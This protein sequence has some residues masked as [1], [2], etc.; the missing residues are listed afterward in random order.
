LIR[1]SKN[2]INYHYLDLTDK[3][4]VASDFYYIIPND[5]IVV[6]PINAKFRNLSLVNWPIFLTAI[7]TLATVYLLFYNTQ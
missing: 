2:K 6:K 3:E 7:T 5:V 4:I 1:E